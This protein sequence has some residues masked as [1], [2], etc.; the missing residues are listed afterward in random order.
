M[1]PASNFYPFPMTEDASNQIMELT[2][3]LIYMY[4]YIYISMY[5]FDVLNK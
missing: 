3:K 1:H 2:V 4:I 5:I